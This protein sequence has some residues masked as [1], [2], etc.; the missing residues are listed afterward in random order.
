MLEEK[1]EYPLKN[2]D[3]SN[4]VN[5]QNPFKINNAYI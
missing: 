1:D 5:N 2:L 3:A 4:I